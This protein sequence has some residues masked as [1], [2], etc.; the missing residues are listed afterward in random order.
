MLAKHKA[1]SLYRPSAV[2]FAQTLVDLPVF[3]F[4]IVIF[5]IIVYF[6]VGLQSDAGLYFAF[7][8][9]CF[10]LYGTF[11]C[12]FRA[13]GYAFA[14]YNDASKVAGMA[15]TAFTLVSILRQT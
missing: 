4:Q 12:L 1:Y 8:L 7:L 13:I 14:T 5:T 9:F 11:T 3:L 2:L 15:F 6:M 10:V